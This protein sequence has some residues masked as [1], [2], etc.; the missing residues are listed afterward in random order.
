[1]HIK[2]KWLMLYTKDGIGWVRLFRVGFRWKDTT[3]HRLTFSERN[4]YRRHLM[5][6][7]WSF[8]WLAYA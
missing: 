7:K 8:G 5:I 1:M 4:G 3:K 6:G 2:T